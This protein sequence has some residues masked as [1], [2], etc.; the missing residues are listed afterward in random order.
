MPTI[1]PAIGRPDQRGHIVEEQEQGNIFQRIPLWIWIA[2]GVVVIF[3]LYTL[4]KGGQSGSTSTPLV[5]TSPSAG[6]DL[7]NLDAAL[8]QILENQNNLANQLNNNPPSGGGSNTGGNLRHYR[9]PVNQSSPSTGGARD[10]SIIQ[11]VT[12]NGNLP[13]GQALNNP[14]NDNWNRGAN[15]S[16]PA[17]GIR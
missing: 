3:A 17:A 8:Q 14:T 11:F 15:Q 2:L 1:A 9:P 10:M 4:S 7:T 12:A 16:A 5:G 13:T 6:P